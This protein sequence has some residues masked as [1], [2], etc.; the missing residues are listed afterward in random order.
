MIL[1]AC[2]DG[3]YWLLAL[4]CQALWEIL[5]DKTSLTE[6]QLEEKIMEIDLRD[7]KKDG[8]M[9]RAVGNCPKCQKPLSQRHAKCLYCGEDIDK[10]HM[11][12]V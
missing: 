2:E 6:D 12:Y 3:V 5:R 1:T 7:G 11:F 9:G 10:E 4:V 8:K